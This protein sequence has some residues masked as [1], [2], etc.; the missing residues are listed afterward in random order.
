MISITAQEVCGQVSLP[1]ASSAASM[2]V[3]P[4]NIVAIRISWPNRGRPE[5][6]Q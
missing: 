4:F 2:M 6:N 3:A 5:D 1:A